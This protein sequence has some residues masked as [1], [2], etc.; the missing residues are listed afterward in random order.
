MYSVV[1]STVQCVVQ[2]NT[3]YSVMDRTYQGAVQIM[4]STGNGQY[5]L[6]GSAV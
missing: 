3:Q 4:G 1:G 5:Y 2:C 6:V